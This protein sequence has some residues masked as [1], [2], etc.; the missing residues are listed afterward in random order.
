M[1]VNNKEIPLSW[2]GETLWKFTPL[3][4]ELIFIAVCLRLIGLVEPFIFQVIIDRILPFQ[5]EASLVV[6]VAVFAA[7]SL[8]QMGFE[9][10]ST[11]LNMIIGN[12]IT[13][14]LGSRIFDHLFKLPIGFSRKWQVGETM[15]RI[16]ET[17]TIRSF[18]VGTSMRTFLDLM[19]V[20]VY[21]AVLL[22]L[23]PLLTMIVLAALPLQAAIYFGFGPFLRKRLRKNFDAGAKHQSQMVENISGIASVKALGAEDVMLSSLDRTLHNS[24]ETSFR[25]GTLN[26]VSSKLIF[27]IDKTLT[28]SIIFFGAKLVFSGEM[29]LGELIAFHLLSDRIIQPISNFSKVWESWQNIRISRQRLGDIVNNEQEPFGVLPKLPPDI[30]PKLEMESVS[31]SYS[32]SDK[33]VLDS[34]NFVARANSLSLV[35]GPS[36]IGKSTFGRLASGIDFPQAGRVLL[37]GLD[38]SEFDPHDVRSKITYVPQDPYLFS[39]T[40]RDNLKLINKSATDEDIGASLEAA[41]AGDL[42]YQLP[43]GLDTKVG[44]RGAAL[45]G[46]QR[47]RIAIARSL[48]T[49]PKVIVL[50]EPTSALDEKAQNEIAANLNK[51][52]S[53]TTIIVITHR[54][55]AFEG[56]DQSID[57]ESANVRD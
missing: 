30:N 38:I 31:F 42:I 51:L 34:F 36:G 19:F 52:K 29:T 35:I 23:S 57:F 44:E 45:S 56:V 28:I 53:A 21:V 47:Q 26:L 9:V 20:F 49:N 10:L 18:L 16:G 4:I 2:F 25:V 43:Q 15:A 3:Y 8:F 11:L 46:G 13:K 37:D 14:E 5:R 48:L 17:D 55:E 22:T 24:I 7:V 32:N 12:R 54:P 50:D 39:G 6:V 41:A 27:V 40:V 1:S 33:L